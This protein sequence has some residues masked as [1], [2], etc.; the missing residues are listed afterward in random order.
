MP[1]I[2]REGRKEIDPFVEA[3]F[4]NLETR[5]DMNYAITKLL[6]KYIK[7]AGLKYR[8]L[9]D[10]IGIVECV[11]LELYRKIVSNYEDIK[12]DENRDIE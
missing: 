12:I 5:G 8:N 10:A 7:R 11:K 3:L 2:K 1:Y 6:H 9:N 4:S